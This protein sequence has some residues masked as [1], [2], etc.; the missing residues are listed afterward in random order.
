MK[1][2][3]DCRETWHP[4][5]EKV[6]LD[7]GDFQIVNDENEVI[8]IFE[9]KTVQDLASSIVDGRFKEQKQRMLATVKE[10]KSICYIIEE[11][12]SLRSSIPLATLM[13]IADNLQLREGF[14]VFYSEN[15][16]HTRQMI[17]FIFQK[18]VESPETYTSCTAQDYLSCVKVKKSKNVQD[19]KSCAV[20]QLVTIP[21]VTAKAAQAILA[22]LGC[23]SMFDFM[24]RMKDMDK[25]SFVSMIS[26]IKTGERSIG[27]KLATSIY[28]SLGGK[29]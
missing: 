7:V 28:E 6:Q 18:I 25:A 23:E 12:K 26:K 8:F 19:P 15:V 20:L 10:P 5:P 1:L 14:S 3:V 2:L 29:I 11:S 9:R 13:Q 16:E 4:E 27:P 21:R 17:D 22:T 24:M